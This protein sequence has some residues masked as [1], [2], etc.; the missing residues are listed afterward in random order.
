MEW[1]TLVSGSGL[2]KIL[3]LEYEPTVR[4]ICKQAREE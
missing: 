4:N 3:V 1:K 2:K